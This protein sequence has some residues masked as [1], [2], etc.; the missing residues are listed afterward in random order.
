MC[1]AVNIAIFF[2]VPGNDPVNHLAGFMGRSC[3]IE[4]YKGFIVYHHIKDG[5]IMADV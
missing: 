4:I 5:E 1:P 2:F 3:I